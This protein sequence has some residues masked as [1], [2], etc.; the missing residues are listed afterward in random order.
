MKYH[1]TSWALQSDFQVRSHFQCRSSYL[2]PSEQSNHVW[3]LKKL[4]AM[5]PH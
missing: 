4:H 5:D 2:L 1:T 3:T